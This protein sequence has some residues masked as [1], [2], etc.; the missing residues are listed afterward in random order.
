M[1]LQKEEI[2]VIENGINFKKAKAFLE[3]LD[4]LYKKKITIPN[5]RAYVQENIK[6]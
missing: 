6:E 5:L 2:E 4:M 1:A 3:T